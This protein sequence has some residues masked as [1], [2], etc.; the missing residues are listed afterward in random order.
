MATLP[1]G[2]TYT[3][4]STSPAA[5][6]TGG[7]PEPSV[8]TLTPSTDHTQDYQ[9]LVWPN[10]AD[11]LPGTH[12]DASFGVDAD[13][14]R[15]PV[16]STVEVTT[17]VHA[18]ADVRLVPDVTPTLGGVDVT[19]SDAD[20]TDDIAVKVVPLALT[21]SE[22]STES[23]LPRGLDDQRTTYTLRIEAAPQGG[24]DTLHVDDYLPAALHFLGCANTTCQTA[25]TSAGLV[26]DPAGQP[27]GLYT[28]L[29]W[30]IPTIAAGATLTL[31]Y[32]AAAAAISQDSSA[33]R[34]NPDPVPAT[35][36]ATLSA[37]LY[38]GPVLASTPTSVSGISA[39]ENVKIVDLALH[40]EMKTSSGV[41]VA[42]DIAQV[43]L[44]LRTGQYANVD[45]IVLTD[46]V[47]DGLCPILPPLAPGQV[48][49]SW[50]A[51]CP[52]PGAQTVTIGGGATVTS[53]TANSDGTFTVQFAVPA[54]STNA[55]TT[56]TY[57]AHMRSVYGS[58]ARTSSGDTFSAGAAV[59]AVTDTGSLQVPV[60][61]TSSASLG[62]AA[63]TLTKEVLDNS[64]RAPLTSAA[65]C[66][67]D[68]PAASWT[69]E[70]ATNA[71]LGDLLCFRITAHTA[72]G[73]AARNVVISDFVPTGTSLVD[74][75]VTANTGAV[76]VTQVTS[77]VWELGTTQAGSRYVPADTTVQI[78]VLARVDSVDV[79]TVDLRGNLAK[80]R[81]E[82]SANQAVAAR[83]GVD[84]QI[85][86]PAPL[87][88]D[89][90]ASLDGGTTW[91][92]DDNVNVVEGNTVTFRVNVTHAGTDLTGYPLNSVTIW[93]VLPTQFS[94]ADVT[95][96]VTCLSAPSTSTAHHDV[97]VFT[98]TGTDLGSD[99]QLSVGESVT[100][101][102]QV[103]VPTPLSVMSTHTNAAHVVSYTAASTDGRPSGSDRVTF[104]PPSPADPA[105]SAINAPAASD[106]VT[107]TL[108]TP[109]LTKTLTGTS[110]VAA[111]N[112][113]T[114]ATLGEL[115]TFSYSLTVP[116]HT[117][118][119]SGAV[120]DR[121][122]VTRA[123]IVSATLTANPGGVATVSTTGTLSLPTT[124]TNT[125]DAPATFTVELTARVDST[126][127]V[128]GAVLTNTA[129]LSAALTPAGTVADRVTSNGANVT[130][131]V[132]NP[133]LTKRIMSGSSQVTSI[134]T[135]AAQPV[136]Y[137][138]T[139]ANPSGLPAA[140]DTV[141]TDCVPAGMHVGAV[142]A[143]A[144]LSTADG[145]GSC[146]A[147]R[148]ILTWTVGPLTGGATRTLDYT[149][150][151]PATA[152]S[153]AS[154][155]N[156]ATLTASSLDDGVNSSTTSKERVFTRTSS[157]TVTITRPTGAKVVDDPSAVPGQARQYTVTGILPVNVNLYALAVIDS[158]PTGLT[159][160]GPAT[161]TCTGDATW[162]SSCPTLTPLASATSAGTTKVGWYLGDVTAS[163]AVRGFT[164]TYSA[165]V[166][167][168]GTTPAAG[169][170]LSNSVRLMWDLAS[171][172]AP[173]SAGASYGTTQGPW[174]APILIK[175]P[176]P[177][178]AVTVSDA[179]IDPAQIVTYGVTTTG[180]SA[181]KTNVPAYNVA[182]T[183]TVPQGVVPLTDA[184]GLRATDG[185]VVAAGT[186]H[187]DTRTITWTDAVLAAGASATRSFH[188]VLDSSPSL[189]GSALRVNADITSW[190]SLATN[191][192]LYT[193]A[194]DV[195]VDVTPQF[196]YVT[197]TKTQNVPNPVYRGQHVPFTVTATNTGQSTALAV[198]LSDTL[199]AAWT[200]VP[201][202]ATV[203]VGSEAATAV[204]PTVVT[205][206]TG[207]G[208]QQ[209]L[210][211]PSVATL[212][213]GSVV[214]V[215]YQATPSSSATV[216]S[217]TAHTNM[218]EIVDVTDTSGATHFNGGAGSFH[219][220]PVSVTARLNASDVAVTSTP[221]GA[222]VAGTST[223]T[224][225]IDVVNNGP[226]P[227]AGVQLVDVPD[228]PAGVSVVS[229]TGSGWTCTS[230]AEA[231][232]CTRT[233]ADDT[234]ASGAHWPL[235][236]TVAITSTVPS[237][238]SVAHTATVSST[239]AD[240]VPS[241]NVATR[242]A[243][244][245]T[246]AD[247][248][249][250][251]NAAAAAVAAGSSATWQV[252]V[253]NFG[254]S[255]SLA[256]SADPIRVNLA[257]PAQLNGAQVTGPDG[258]TCT[259]TGTTA[260]CQQP[261]SLAYTEGFTLTVTGTLDQ[262]T[263]PGQQLVV[264]ATV[265]PV[266]AQGAN[267]RTDVAS[268]PV[269][270]TGEDH[271]S[272]T[273]TL[274]GSFVAGQD[275]T[276]QFAVS[277]AGPSAARQVV[278]TDTLPAG[279]HLSAPVT[280]PT[281]SC[282]ATGQLV[283]CTY[284]GTGGVL[285]AGASTSVQIVATTDPTLT[286]AVT[287]TAHVASATNP[288]HASSTWAQVPSALSDLGLTKSHT[289]STVNAGTGTT[290]NLDAVNYGPSTAAAGATIVDLM[291]AGVAVTT[292]PDGCTLAN[293]S[294]RDQLT[295]TRPTAWA[296][297]QH[298]SVDVPVHVD[299][300]VVG[301]LTNTARVNA[302]AGTNQGADVHPDIASADLVVTSA[303]DLALT[304]VADAAVVT[305]GRQV[306]YTLTATNNGP[307]DASD[308][309]LTDTLPPSLTAAHA[310]G[311]T[312]AC[313]LAGQDLTCQVGTLKPG[314]HQQVSVTATLV[315][316]T[317]AGSSVTNTATV[318]SSTPDVDG[319]AHSSADATSTVTTTAQAT[320]QVTKS[321][322]TQQ[323]VA[324]ATATWDLDVTNAGPSDLTGPVTL[325]DTLPAQ[326][327][328]TSAA[329]PD[330]TCAGAAQ[331]VTCVYAP[332]SGPLGAGATTSRVRVV[333]VL[334]ADAT[335][336]VA[337][338]TATATSALSGPSAPASADV[339]VTGAADLTVDVDA[340]STNPVPGTD[341]VITLSVTNDGPSTSR[342]DAAHPI[343]VTATLPTGYTLPGDVT[344]TDGTCTVTSHDPDVV[345][346]ALQRNLLA[347]SS[348]TWQLP[349]HLDADLTGTVHVDAHV[350]PALTAQTAAN[351]AADD[352]TDTRT[353]A[354][355]ADLEVTK[356]L[357][358]AAGD[359]ISGQQVTWQVQVTNAGPSTSR[360]SSDHPTRVV[361]TLPTGVTFAGAN[362]DR[363]AC[364][365]SGQQVICDLTGDLNVGDTVQLS[366]NPPHG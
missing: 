160:T 185:A 322:T 309:L 352:D 244:V 366:L 343:L 184:T 83:A 173:T 288:D 226:D 358:T 16:G 243:A 276:F 136:T 130:V 86:P 178:I 3:A 361:D 47:A 188:A 229:L 33:N 301:T 333:A 54:M 350:T 336:P 153:G 215:T 169:T 96:P 283:S 180:S 337:P 121:L 109:T 105:T 260:T 71:R 179:T 331:L 18:S 310:S 88:V 212:P 102:Y 254:P 43:S 82:N 281:W 174:T 91:D 253:T 167:S 349:V 297:G 56:V 159:L 65:T 81:Q 291:P 222:F 145:S 303:A 85:L 150:T 40:K 332:A 206:G 317:P 110:V 195:S 269:T 42:E 113:A 164:I 31:Q 272:V 262:G 285:A 189:T 201:G 115:A 289:P 171:R 209:Q 21:K 270:A 227:A 38:H 237:G 224:F 342:A 133:T 24:S 181:A 324:G 107:L 250:A 223:N 316:S 318:T 49:G 100:F 35:N 207:A 346:C 166:T 25:L 118:I 168:A 194:A 138:M 353:M 127:D 26:N 314:Q 340:G 59:T 263:A 214:V 292:V 356:S 242:T 30:D 348:V 58:G 266:T 312:G 66:S 364:T 246:V 231:W 147:G 87:S 327:T 238:T 92:S 261:A 77:G 225:T 265:V 186:W 9:V 271:L 360:G 19:Q 17:A 11:L 300:S 128:H 34:Q 48:H 175:E 323:V 355:V 146:A 183:V 156:T 5:S 192:R 241:N 299:S 114:S 120:S 363:W 95:T 162:V 27:A 99:Q 67:A 290:V 57:P 213:T 134:A 345:T 37:A 158:L 108:P 7:L 236:L 122:P 172:T 202:T 205:T 298:W 161:I 152:A 357:T 36:T 68:A 258:V 76:P 252:T 69:T 182:T 200:Y 251:V 228:L 321:P 165:K 131:V 208:A 190:S 1:P 249:V 28:H 347:R 326:F 235:T 45:Q 304:K 144:T 274:V 264:G 148:E 359:V 94:C 187:A 80:F 70:A 302:P 294:G 315:S 149:A 218:V 277:N 20:A 308:V 211:F 313:T 354:P 248:T 275:A 334:D 157:A 78:T 257:L 52:Q 6:A 351:D 365:G 141:V 13:P 124:Y 320:L 126:T 32:T 279:M 135:G 221:N 286:S 154:Y 217:G 132:A 4:G 12:I 255:Q 119:L 259:L 116:A 282:T 61:E 55:T 335:D 50:P 234:L 247:V 219:A 163:G 216:G 329:G 287:N 296:P 273:K 84:F 53:V 210:T 338:N 278:L 256:T 104:T 232:T 79:T 74:W 14:Q 41:F 46:T 230:N 140:Y 2:V 39:H 101:T 362:G 203:K 295:C 137:R 63:A 199:P 103:K 111:G 197:L 284:T 307:S 245:V 344:T 51:D 125:T 220:A 97:L 139:V 155:V 193:D 106:D 204:E 8:T 151:T 339:T 123:T 170:T 176:A 89:K 280:T 22:P 117:S 60:R 129:V 311:P 268:A 306:T 177:T 267:V 233:N 239:T 325:T 319:S 191:G 44:Q 15:Y 196:P 23:E 10:V 341:A 143:G 75:A 72:L 142:P 305:A 62:T 198:E 98:L 293:V 328:F 64:A 93:D 240:D 73:S 29:S 112:P 90:A 330:W